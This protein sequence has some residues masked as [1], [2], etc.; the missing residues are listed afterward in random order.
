MVL[1]LGNRCSLGHGAAS[2][3]WRRHGDCDRVYFQLEVDACYFVLCPVY[4]DCGDVAD[5]ADAGDY[6][7][8]IAKFVSN[9]L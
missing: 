9:L 4:Y 2:T 1:L 8:L 7:Q 6:A 3:R 5:E